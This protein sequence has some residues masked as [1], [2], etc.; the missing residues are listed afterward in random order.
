M[1]RFRRS[2]ALRAGAPVVALSL[3]AILAFVILLRTPHEAAPGASVSPNIP[4]TG[5]EGV[6]VQSDPSIGV[7]N[8][9][10]VV[11]WTDSRATLPDV[12]ARVIG[13]PQGDRRVSDPGPHYDTDRDHTPAVLVQPDGRAFAAFTR[14]GAIALARYDPAAGQWVSH[15]NVTPGGLP[16]YAQATYP[17]LAGDG[18]GNLIVVWQDFRNADQGNPSNTGADIYAAR[19]NGNTM[20]CAAN[21]K[22]N[23]DS[24]ARA[25]QSHPS[26]AMRGASV[27][28]VWQDERELGAESPQVYARRSGDGGVTWSAEGKVNLAN[29]SATQPATTFDTAGA[30]WVV[31]EHR[32]QLPTDP[33]DIY[34]ARWNGSAWTG[35]ARVDAAP[36]R[37]RASEPAIAATTAG[38]FVAWTDYRHGSGNANIYAARWNGSAWVESVV[39]SRTAAQTQP[40]LAA[41]G[42]DV[43][44]S[45]QDASAGQQDIRLARWNGSAWLD[46]GQANESAIRLSGQMFPTLARNASSGA[47]YLTFIDQRNGYK[48]VLMSRLN[49]GALFP[50]WTAPQVLPTLAANGSTIN[51][52]APATALDSAGRLHA[53]WSEDTW[54]RGYQIYHS[55]YSG[56]VW[57]APVWVTEPA[58]GADDRAR[59]S[60][61]LAA[62]GSEMAAVWTLALG[63][64]WPHTYIVQVSWLNG[65][66]WLT[67]TQVFAQPVYRDNPQPAIALDNAGNTYVAWTGFYDG[68]GGQRAD[69]IV[70]RYD[71]NTRQW[72]NTR[73]VN[74]APSTLNWC[75][76]HTPRLATDSQNRVHV[77]WAGCVNWRGY[78][79]HSWSVDGGASWI[80]PSVIIA[81]LSDT[82]ALPALTVAANDELQVLFP[83]GAEG[84]ARFY[85]S[86]WSG[87]AWTAPVAVSD[88]PTN[89]HVA[90]DYNNTG[91]YGGDSA[92]A[93]IF[94][95]LNSRTIA[96]FPDRRQANVPRLYGAAYFATSA[97]QMSRAFVPV[98]RR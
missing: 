83:N 30:A 17:A 16:W 13:S 53:L 48:D 38:A 66:N 77:V 6:T 81:P 34:A 37:I 65:A 1:I 50:T 24:A 62:R 94:D 35:H 28:V 32:A 19:C 26:V 39:V 85:L 86:R 87:G 92:G 9:R 14:N 84:Q 64:S 91:W 55:V 21:V 43:Y 12:Y 11:A 78:L 18:Q 96:V 54:P 3:M 80:S 56:T 72:V 31:W 88:G 20:T 76:H 15:T 49:P 10:V 22:I 79:F 45:W 60:P 51:S 47:I 29:T 70:A 4:V 42:S 74:S 93:L 61:A 27:V 59:E 71:K 36:A 2:S 68:G 5:D 41:A 63:D 33:A 52:E 73:R 25:Q 8:G 58:D 82:S 69:I 89:W 46:A 98:I 95:G 67:P 23:A 57:D 40:A 75:Y 90:G 97:P 7:G 44:A